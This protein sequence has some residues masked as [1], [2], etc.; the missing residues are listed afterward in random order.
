MR[1]VGR[2]INWFT[3]YG[4]RF[5]IYITR[6]LRYS[7]IGGIVVLLDLLVLFILVEF[8]HIFYLMAAALSFIVA[9]SSNYFVQREWGFKDTKEGVKRGYFYF[10]F[11]GIIGIFST[12]GLLAFMVEYVGLHYLFARWLVALIVGTLMFFFHY[13][14]TF[15]IRGELPNPFKRG[16]KR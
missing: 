1:R 11:F 2:A 5:P 7:S 9:H 13:R 15:R 4:G 8:F 10:I 6:L 3:S 14:I 12:L 16:F